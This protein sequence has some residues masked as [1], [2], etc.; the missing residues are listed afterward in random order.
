[1]RRRKGFMRIRYTPTVY[2][3]VNP[4]D[5]LQYISVYRYI[6]ICSIFAAHCVHGVGSG[7]APARHTIHQDPNPPSAWR[8][9]S[10]AAVVTIAVKLS[11]PPTQPE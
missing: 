7:V 1:M 5:V 3:F 10:Y 9:S 4:H 8:V 6:Y 2:F 11:H